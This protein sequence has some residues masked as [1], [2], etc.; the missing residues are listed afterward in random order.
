[1]TAP[2][3]DRCDVLVVL[4]ALRAEGTPVMTRDLCVQW[5]AAGIAPWVLTLFDKPDD[6]HPEFAALGVPVVRARVPRTGR[7]RY[8]AIAREVAGAARALRPRAVLSMPFGWHAFVLAGARWAGVPV[9]AAHVGNYPPHWHRG[10]FW[11]FKAEV[12]LGRL[13]TDRLVCCSEYVRG[14]VLRHFPVPERATAVVY[15]GCDVAAVEARAA[16]ERARR[17]AGPFR[18]GMVATL[19]VH[20]DHP[21][22][23]EAHARLRAWLPAELWLIGNGSRRAELQALAARLGVG[24]SVAFLG[25]RR[26]VPELL[27]QLDAFAFS[28]KPDEGLG[29]ALVEA[30]AARVP[31]VATD[32]GA[33]REVLDGG[34]LGALVPYGDAA[35]MA[36]A[37]ERIAVAPGAFGPVVARAADRA[38]DVFSKEAMARGYAAQLGLG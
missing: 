21:T 37:L 18:V 38:R 16:R 23:I 11:K 4:T 8:W 26:D 36:A 9:T 6:L 28:A 12:L 3:T 22:L 13:V 33:C 5:K 29:I 34:A 31:I 27:G 7:H 19:E 15:N 32:V 25:T 20:K 35:A 30:M 17:A 24:T 10:A 1:M 14:G 2:S